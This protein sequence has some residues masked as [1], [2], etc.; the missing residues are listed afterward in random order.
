[1]TEVGLDAGIPCGGAVDPNRHVIEISYDG[2]VA[3][4][5]LLS[6]I[7]RETGLDFSI[8]AA[9]AGRL[10]ETAFGRFTIELAVRDETQLQRFLSVCESHDV[11]S[12]L[13]R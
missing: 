2:K 5:P 3:A 1:L 11:R 6:C 4:Q 9:S 10:K 7:A 12:E 8:L 13:A